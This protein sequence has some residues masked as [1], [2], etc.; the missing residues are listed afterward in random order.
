MNELLPYCVANA[1]LLVIVAG[2]LWSSAK[3]TEQQET[4][5]ALELEM[6]RGVVAQSS[7]NYN[8]QLEQL[9]L[10]TD[11]LRAEDH[12]R[13]RRADNTMPLPHIQRLASAAATPAE[14]AELTGLGK[15]EAEFLMNITLPKAPVTTADNKQSDVWIGASDE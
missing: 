11:N 12:Q 8:A 6:L 5:M 7:Q 3:R 1:V 13:G 14:L 4:K 15:A 9:R 2:L 10:V